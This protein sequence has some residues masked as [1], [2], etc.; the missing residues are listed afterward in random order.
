MAQEVLGLTA[1]GQV[2]ALAQHLGGL[3]GHVREQVLNTPAPWKGTPVTPLILAAFANRVHVA[4]Q[5]LASGADPDVL[6]GTHHTALSIAAQ[7]DHPDMVRFLLANRA[8]PAASPTAPPLFVAAQHGHVAAARALLTHVRDTS[9]DSP[10]YI[11]ALHNRTAVLRVLVEEGKFDVNHQ[12]PCTPLCAAAQQGHE[13]SVLYLLS[14]GADPNQPSLDGTAALY[15]AASRG[16]ADIVHL[17]LA[18]DADSDLVTTQ[19]GTTPLCVASSMGFL[20]TVI[21]LVR[22]RADLDRCEGDGATPLYAAA[23][24]GHLDIVK[25]LLLYG[26]DVDAVSGPGRATALW[27][28]AREGRV[29]ICTHLLQHGADP[30]TALSAAAQSG[31]TNIV[32][33]LIEHGASVDGGR[34]TALCAAAQE[35]RLDM[36]KHL[37]SIGASVDAASE[38][39]ATPL[40]IAVQGQKNDV[41]QALLEAGADA[42]AG[43]LV[44][45]ATEAG[46]GST[47]QQLLLAGADPNTPA[48]GSGATPLYAACRRGRLDLVEMLAAHA[49]VDVQ[50]RTS[51]VS[52]LQAATVMGHDAIV[53]ALADFCDADEVVAAAGV[54][55]KTGR[56]EIAA[57]LRDHNARRSGRRKRRKKKK[58][59]GGNGG[60]IQAAIE[61]LQAE[62]RARTDRVLTA[63]MVTAGEWDRIQREVEFLAQPENRLAAEF[64]DAIL[65]HLSMLF[66]A[67][68]VLFSKL[69][70]HAEAA[71]VGLVDALR[72]AVPRSD[73]P[74]TAA[75]VAVMA[76]IAPTVSVKEQLGRAEKALPADAGHAAALCEDLAMRLA[77][78]TTVTRRAI[79]VGTSR[80]VRIGD[81]VSALDIADNSALLHALCL[82]DVLLTGAAGVSHNSERVCEASVRILRPLFGDPL[83]EYESVPAAGAQESQDVHDVD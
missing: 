66:C 46:D 58:T 63:S 54:A 59:V 6:T 13:V 43:A 41:V 10:L 9:L 48:P 50:A 21:V 3:T 82:V 37:I 49:D 69:I 36:V 25:Y 30:N 62:M 1:E 17:L 22:A 47:L 11:A 2:P 14:V 51:N 74:E 33:F 35:G 8:N 44:A 32:A 15:V 42:R 38:D 61:Q 29:E 73:A 71:A 72:D 53:R 24:A 28:A 52:P 34:R 81:W 55:E 19:G 78:T 67:A 64:R 77:L 27:A 75:L 79:V 83:Y 23:F 31:H 12:R 18:H 45:I 68:T 57:W 4:A 26:A 39:G 40:L 20:E 60:A 76:R 70:S 16:R 56:G 65:D 5:L 7:E 80:W